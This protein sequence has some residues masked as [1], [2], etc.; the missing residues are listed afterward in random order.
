MRLAGAHEQARPSPPRGQVERSLFGDRSNSQAFAP[1]NC[2]TR[3]AK[4]TGVSCIG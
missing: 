3:L 2:S 1:M 4:Y